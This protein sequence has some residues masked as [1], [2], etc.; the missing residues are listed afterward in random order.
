M[1]LKPREAQSQGLGYFK[2][3]G[4]KRQ[5]FELILAAY[6]NRTARAEAIM[7]SDPDQIVRQDP[8]SGL[9][10]LHVAIFRG[11][12]ELVTLLAEHPRTDFQMKD[13]FDRRP[14]DMLDY[15]RNQQ[16]F[17]LVMEGTYPDEMRALD[18]CE[19]DDDP[20]T[21]PGGPAVPIK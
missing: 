21:P 3:G 2:K 14:V 10:A 17:N 19:F 16:I 9:T 4:P 7:Q 6:Y 11:N 5:H 15:T 18:L 12:V 13:N 20:P 1:T 8:H